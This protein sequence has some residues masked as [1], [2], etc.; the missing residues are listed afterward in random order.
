MGAV[1]QQRMKQCIKG[2][3]YWAHDNGVNKG[4]SHSPGI[5]AK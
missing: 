2:R 5:T 3:A 1:A 4:S